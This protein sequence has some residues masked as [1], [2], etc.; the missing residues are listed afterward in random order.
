[1]GWPQGWTDIHHPLTRD[2]DLEDPPLQVRFKTEDREMPRQELRRRLH[3]IGNGWDARAAEGA[4][5]LLRS[6]YL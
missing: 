4:Y 6:R 3:A 5:R 1:M 2:L